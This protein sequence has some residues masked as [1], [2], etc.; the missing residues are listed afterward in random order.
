ML[1]LVGVQEGGGGGGDRGEAGAVL[2]WVE[3]FFGGVGGWGGVEVFESLE[4]ERARLSSFRMEKRER[5][6]RPRRRFLL[7]Q[8]FLFANLNSCEHNS[9]VVLSRALQEKKEQPPQP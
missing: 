2:G 1:V 3:F 6:R 9:L 8:R 7:V 5:E 4:K